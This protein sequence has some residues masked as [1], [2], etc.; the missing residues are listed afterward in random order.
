MSEERENDTQVTASRRRAD[1]SELVSTRGV[2]LIVSGDDFGRTMVVEG[3]PAVIG[4]GADADLTV[5]DPKV[6]RRHCEILR[7]PHGEFTVQDLGSRNGT[8]LNTRPL[9]R[10]E[11]LSYGDRV[12][13]GDT[14]LRFFLEEKAE[15]K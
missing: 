9:R 6:S 4:R 5:A 7:D 11:T 15:R 3:A 10:P 2:L 8:F 14:L 1:V 12:M 13:V